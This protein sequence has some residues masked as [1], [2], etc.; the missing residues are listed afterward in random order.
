MIDLQNLPV[1]PDFSVLTDREVESSIRRE[2]VNN[3]KF[4]KRAFVFLKLR[5]NQVDLYDPKIIQMVSVDLLQKPIQLI[6]TEIER[7]DKDLSQLKENI[8]KLE[9]IYPQFNFFPTEE[10]IENLGKEL[11]NFHTNFYKSTLEIANSRLEVLKKEIDEYLK[12]ASDPTQAYVAESRRR[13]VKSSCEQFNFRISLDNF[14][15]KE[16]LSYFLI[17]EVSEHVYDTKYPPNR[18]FDAKRVIESAISRAAIWGEKMP[19]DDLK[20]F[21]IKKCADIQEVLVN[22]KDTQTELQEQKKKLNDLVYPLKT[23]QKEMKSY[24]RLSDELDSVLQ[25]QNLVTL[26]KDRVKERNETISI[27]TYH[28]TTSIKALDEVKLAL[29]ARSSAIEEVK[30][31]STAIK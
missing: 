18:A 23:T 2:L 27:L 8:E 28:A 5:I 29:K 19:S 11:E 22:L 15:N 21:Y 9:A 30:A 4:W 24:L 1:I 3:E 13:A 6:D 16:Y 20:P 17:K 10:E 26:L 14:P 7:I 12:Y 31:I 25:A